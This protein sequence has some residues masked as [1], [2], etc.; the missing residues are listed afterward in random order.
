MTELVAPPLEGAAPADVER[1]KLADSATLV[2]WKAVR[3]GEGDVLLLAC[4]AA[5]IPGWIEDMR[6]SIEARSFAFAMTSSRKVVGADFE[7]K[8]ELGHVSLVSSGASVGTTRTFLGWSAASEVVTCFATCA[9]PQVVAHPGPRVCDASVAAARLA[10]DAPP[11]APGIGLRATTW[12]IHHSRPTLAWGAA[13]T[14]CLA[15]LAIVMRRRPR[16]RI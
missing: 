16:S 3:A 4:V 13:L 6:P 11:P 8:L 14:I 15:A 12:A 10:G 1:P 9:T 2:Q 7:P 5:P